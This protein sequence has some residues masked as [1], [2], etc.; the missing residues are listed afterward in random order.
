MK[1]MLLG[2]LLCAGMTPNVFSAVWENEKQWS[3]E[4][5]IKYSEW[6]AKNWNIDIFSDDDSPYYAIPTDCADGAYTMRMI[7]A[8]E[9]KLPF[10]IDSKRY[11]TI[12]SNSM[13]RW[14]GNP[15]DGLQ[16]SMHNISD[17]DKATINELWP[18]YSNE[19]K[20]FWQFVR[21]VNSVTSTWTF[22]HDTLSAPLG[23][24][25]IKPGMVL[26]KRRYHTYTVKGAGI[27]GAKTST[28]RALPKVAASNNEEM[29]WGGSIATSGNESNAGNMV[30]IA[31]EIKG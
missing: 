22:P 16:S 29:V 31:Q 9:N 23:H 13:T 24:G 3:D 17:K 10:A 12:I 4:E 14:D 7:Y 25:N 6:V 11:N 19:Y 15:D 21:Y 20:K 27:Q 8:Y 2:F 28:N 5:E 30:M 1:K 26:L 18:T